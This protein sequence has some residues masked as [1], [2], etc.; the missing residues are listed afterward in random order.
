MPAGEAYWDPFDR[1]LHR[2]P[3][4]AW[5]RMRDEAPVYHNDRFDFYALS[6]FDDVF[7]ASLE[8]D[9]FSSAHGVTLDMISDEPLEPPNPMIMMDPPG[10]TAMR[11]IV[12]RT[13]TP[14][15]MAQL[16][17]R[18]HALCSEYLDP[19]VGASGFDYV[20]DF[21]MRLPV[22]VISTLLGFPPEDH[23]QLRVWSDAQIHRE[24]DDPDLTPEGRAAFAQLMTYYQEQIQRRR[25]QPTDDIVSDLMASELVEADGST[26]HLD[27]GELLVFMALINL[28]GNETVARLLGWAG[29][30][31]AR[32]PEQRAKLVADPSLIPNAVEELLRYEAPSPV[33]G[34][35]ATKP[36]CFHGV[37]IPAGSK[38]LLVTG[39]AGRDDR[40][41]PDPDVFDVER[42][43]TR[44]VS[45][46]HGAHYCLGAAL[47]RIE[48]KVG[49]EET[50]RRFPTWDVDPEAVQFVH[51]NSVRGPASLPIL[52]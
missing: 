42:S 47:A 23:D 40:E 1:T 28:A 36:S 12:N 16:E 33:Q 29:L 43:I 45:F 39:A 20:Q 7:K 41:Y 25:K 10:H 38:V 18:I 34:R 5:R 19:Y 35:Y 14:R 51:T 49:I 17:D 13:F 30:T 52:F 46:G 50:L 21:S 26:R 37:E 32:F 6:R 4:E 27:D 22:M 31:L 15:R 9:T 3:Y 11:K 8:T 24:P 48:G 44:H 2:D